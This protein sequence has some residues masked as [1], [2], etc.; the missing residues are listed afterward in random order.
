[1]H[2]NFHIFK[3]EFITKDQKECLV[4]HMVMVHQSVE[5]YSEQFAQKLRRRNYTTPK[6]YLDYIGTYVSMLD[7]KNRENKGHQDRLLVGIDKIKEAE[8]QLKKLNEDLAVQKVMVTKRTEEVELL[9]R[10]IAEGTKEASEKKELALVR[11]KE[12][13]VQTVVIDKEKV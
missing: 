3:N 9:L 4:T 13:Q 5:H 6:N 2:K 8:I 12:I 1:V 10:E 11:S 7:K